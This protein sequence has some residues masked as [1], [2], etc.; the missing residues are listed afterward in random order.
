MY[1]IKLLLNTPPK[2]NYID[3]LCSSWTKDNRIVCPR[4]LVEKSA[5]WCLVG[6]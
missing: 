3:L 1:K 5:I 4:A 6:T 2:M